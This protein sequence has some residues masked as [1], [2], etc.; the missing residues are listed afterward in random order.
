MR[1]QAKDE[2][3]FTMG[4]VFL[5]EAIFQSHSGEKPMNIEWKLEE[6][7]PPFILKERQ[8]LAVGKLDL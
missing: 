6:P 2:Y 8:K 7:M 1:E 5:G 3:G 4:C